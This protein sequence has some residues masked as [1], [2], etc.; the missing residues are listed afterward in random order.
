MAIALADAGVRP[1]ELIAA[2]LPSSVEWH[3]FMRAALELNCPWAPL[4]V[5]ATKNK[6]DVKHTLEVLRPKVVVVFDG[7]MARDLQK[8]VPEEMDDMKLR[9]MC[10]GDSFGNWRNVRSLVESSSGNEGILKDLNIKRDLQDVVLLMFTS[11][12][13]ASFP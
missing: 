7:E 12:T 1:G 11:G 13:R 3:V 8:N 4:N 2:Y 10:N 5:K 9:L 6:S